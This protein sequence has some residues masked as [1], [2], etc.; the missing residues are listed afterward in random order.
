MATICVVGL[1]HQA[2]VVSAC[3]ADMGH[4]VCGVGDDEQAVKSLNTGE[5]PIYEPKLKA[6]MRRNLR[7]GRLKYTADYR[8]ALHRAEFAYIAIDTPVGSNDE[9]DLSSIFDA[10]RHVGQAMPVLSRSPD[11]EWSEGEGAAEGSGELILIVS[12]QVP[13]GTCQRIAAVVEE[14]KQ[15][16]SV[17]RLPSSVLRPPSS[18]PV[19]YVPEFLRLGTAV[20]TFRR[21]DRFVVGADDPAVAE[22]V[23][24][25]YRPLG[26]PIV[27]TNLRTAEMAKHASNAFLATSI[28][29][30]NEMANL[31]DEVGADALQVAQIMKL[32]R[33]IGKYAFL[34]P[35]LGFAG[36]TLGREIRALQKLGQQH[37]CNTP[38]MDAVMTVNQARARLVGQRLQRVYSSL[39]DLQVGILGLTYKPGTSTLRRSIALDIIRDLVAQGASIK[40]FDP[41]ARLDE[42]ADLPPFEPCPDPYAVAQGSDALVLV[43][44]WSGIRDLDLPRLCA[45]MCRPVF[46][47]TSNLFDPARMREAGFIYLGVGRGLKADGK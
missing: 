8:E 44:E 1:W 6:I 14:E 24:G 3:L 7:D 41:L 4:Q 26:R 19:A 27:I 15:R 36:G 31:C 39:E 37:R 21:A 13:V 32:D 34:S 47:D 33:R 28:S 2:S 46:I 45:A 43:T 11:P 9:S 12:A 25:L 17:L 23:A 42:A 18:V 29:F 30:I 20:D 38:M 5:P 40:A 10:A 16:S 35:G 22:R